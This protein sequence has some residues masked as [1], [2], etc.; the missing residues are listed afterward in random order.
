MIWTTSLVI[1]TKRLLK[2]KM[3]K[4]NKLELALGISWDFTIDHWKR[5]D[6]PTQSIMDYNKLVKTSSHTTW[7]KHV[8]KCITEGTWVDLTL[9]AQNSYKSSAQQLEWAGCEFNSCLK[10]RIFSVLLSDRIF[11]LLLN[12]E[13]IKKTKHKFL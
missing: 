6:W 7:Q 1:Y 12:Y 8:T 11:C 10:H 3:V 13:T 9:L 2:R 5:P 4:G